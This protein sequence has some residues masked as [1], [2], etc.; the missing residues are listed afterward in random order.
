MEVYFAHTASYPDAPPLLKAAGLQAINDSEVAELEAA[1]AAVV[2][3]S[4]GAPM[5]Y[6]LLQEVQEW[7][8]ERARLAASAAPD[9]ATLL[10]RERAA[11]EARIAALRAH[12]TPVT[13]QAFHA[14]AAAF[15][16]EQAAAAQGAAAGKAGGEARLTGRQWFKRQEEAQL[17]VEEPELELDEEDGEDD[18]DAWQRRRQDESEEEDSD[19]DALLE[20]MAALKGV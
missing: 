10:A 19:E 9:E 18:R 15:A 14:W 3:E 12:G 5:I 6:T 20:E 16:Q 13:V 2:E 8:N 11:E 4:L 17:P 1:L 7:L